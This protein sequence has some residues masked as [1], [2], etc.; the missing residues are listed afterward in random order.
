MQKPF[1]VVFGVVLLVALLLGP[2]GCMDQEWFVCAPVR[3]EPQPDTQAPSP[4]ENESASPIAA[5]GMQ[6]A[7]HSA[8][9]EGDTLHFTY[10]LR[11]VRWPASYW[12]ITP[13]EDWFFWVHFWDAEG[14][15]M[16]HST[17]VNIELPEAFVNRHVKFAEDKATVELP[18]GARSFTLRFN[19]ELTTKPVAVPE[20]MAA[21]GEY[22]PEP[23]A[24]ADRLLEI[25]RN[26]ESYGRADAEFRWTPADCDPGPL[27]G[28]PRL[29]QWRF[30][31]SDDSPTHGQ[32][33]YA[34][35]AKERLGSYSDGCV[36]I[37]RDKPNPVGQVIVKEAWKPER[38]GADI[39]AFGPAIR[40]VSVREGETVRVVTDMY[41]P[42]AQKNGLFYT[43]KEKAGL[44][45]M[46]KL[47][48][49]TP[50]TDQGWVYGT[51]SAD[52]KTVG[53]V[54]RVA[55]CMGCHEKAP[56]D[57]LFGLPKE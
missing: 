2:H 23:Q 25:A 30:S 13:P 49:K 18:P 52:G 38:V 1:F 40:Q 45:V 17:C 46:F 50:G 34:V 39:R 15:A 4:L 42:F 5:D 21:G 6:V 51:V 8:T 55:N 12:L 26:Y 28:V 48:P 41:L 7:V 10:T 22:H 32:K 56:H 31:A 16:K 36:Y 54:G 57:R 11:W 24:F 47:D 19:R 43:S 14:R 20:Q 27:V 33:L 9:R 44:F 53:S 37:V 3:N 35:F 29:P